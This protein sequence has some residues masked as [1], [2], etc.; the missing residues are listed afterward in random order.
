MGLIHDLNPSAPGGAEPMEVSTSA[1]SETHD[2]TPSSSALPVAP[3]P[4][5][6]GFGKII[7]DDAGN[8]LRV[9]FAADDEQTSQ[10][11]PDI[12][13]DLSVPEVPIGDMSKWVSDLG[14]GSIAPVPEKAGAVVKGEQA[15]LT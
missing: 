13:M 5:P 7:R 11:N 9:E 14:G 3:T 10:E 6:K 15:I 1:N 4:I 12:D 2:V 8:V